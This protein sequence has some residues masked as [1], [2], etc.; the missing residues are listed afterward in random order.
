MD[1][2]TIRLDIEEPVSRLALHRPEALNAM[3]IAMLDELTAAAELLSSARDVRAVIITGEGRG[4]S[5]G[6]DRKDPVIVAAFAG[7]ED[8]TRRAAAAGA[9]A[10]K[11]I[12]EL[13]PAT[14]AAL[15]GPVIG[16][17]IVLAACCDLR[18]CHPDTRFR[19]PE[20][21]LGIPLIWG[22]LPRLV[23]HLGPGRAKEL[24]MLCREF[25]AAEATAW[26][27]VNESPTD[28]ISR[29]AEL[30]AALAA[31]PAVPLGITKRHVADIL[32][33]VDA[34]DPVS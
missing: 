23:R 10:M 29:A 25:S 12:E 4:F 26:G 18:V 21:S 8:A 1:F 13:R 34:A 30:A 32:A 16:G 7:D 28:Y 2:H 6:A 24:V 33:A 5:A 9:A 22:G 15:H 3:S 20:V 17:A 19:I 27:F 11:S 31:M 14:V